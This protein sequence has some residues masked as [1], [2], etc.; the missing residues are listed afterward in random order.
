MKN[1]LYVAYISIQVFNVMTTSI[2]IGFLLFIIND[3]YILFTPYT[4]INIFKSILYAKLSSKE[5]FTYITFVP[6]YTGIVFFLSL[7]FYRVVANIS[8]LLFLKFYKN[9]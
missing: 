6:I 1:K 7:F 4:D 9:K 3:V 8:S 5:V 2:I